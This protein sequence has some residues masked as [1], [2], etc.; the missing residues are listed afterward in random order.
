MDVN[1]QP[2]LTIQISFDY[3]QSTAQKIILIQILRQFQ[4]LTHYLYD[5][6]I[7]M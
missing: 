6:P 5:L 3:S 4:T 2:W 1:I 7:Q